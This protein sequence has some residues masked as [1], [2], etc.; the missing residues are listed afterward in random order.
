V[1]LCGLPIASAPDGGKNSAMS[2][3]QTPARILVVDDEVDTRHLISLRFRQKIRDG[4]YEFLFAGDGREALDLLVAGPPVDMVLSDINMPNM[5]GLAL[6]AEIGRRWPDLK[7]VM[8]SAYGDMQ[9]IR[10]A[11]NNGAFDFVTKPISFEDLSITVEKT[12]AQA[13]RL[14]EDAQ[15]RQRL[16]ALDQEL[17]LAAD[18]QQRSLPKRFPPEAITAGFDMAGAMT[19]AKE[20]GGDSYDVLPLD[21][22]RIGFFVAD[23]SGKG[24]A[25]ALF[26]AEARVAL[27]AKLRSAQCPAAALA[28][29]ND[30]LALDNDDAMFVTVILGILNVQDGQMK[31]ANGGHPPP[32]LRHGDGTVETIRSARARAVGIRAGAAYHATDVSLAPGDAILAFSDGVTEAENGAGELWGEAALAR[33][34]AKTAPASARALV[35]AAVTGA[36]AFSAPALPADDITAFAIAR[37]P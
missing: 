11:M 1:A 36:M 34:L 25:A 24:V 31:I 23:V 9:N 27:R 20:V 12:L 32:L 22:N 8:V 26:M 5:D 33:A 16:A 4:D 7:V 19:P 29:V 2:E 37:G 3:R 21:G 14:K 10:S 35:D 18:L 17:R 13:A 30:I 28:A 15:T 6:L